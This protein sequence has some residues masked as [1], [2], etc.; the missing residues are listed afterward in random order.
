MG[1]TVYTAH[2]ERAAGPKRQDAE[3]SQGASGAPTVRRLTLITFGFKYGHPNANY[4]FDV[5]FL[6]NPAREKRWG[7]F[8]R[9]DDEMRRH[10]LAEPDCRTF[11][12]AAVPLVRALV[13]LD[14][15]CRVGIGCSSGRHRSWIVGEEI[16]R[17]LQA[18]DCRV[19][20]IH[21]EEDYL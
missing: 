17:R 8:A 16:S 11:L 19:R 14:D 13:R 1:R 5:S 4:Y 15:D 3:S 9:V 18:P 6:K 12:D 2:Q 20:L 7:L 21:R 10:L